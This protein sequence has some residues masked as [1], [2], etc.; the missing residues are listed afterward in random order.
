[1]ASPACARLEE[2]ALKHPKNGRAAAYAA[3]NILQSPTAQQDPAKAELLLKQ[4][5]PRTPA[6]PR[7]IMSLGFSPSSDPQW[8]Q[9]SVLFEKAVALR[10]AYSEAHYRLSRAYAHMGRHDEAQQQIALQQQYSQQEKDR[11]NTR[12]QEMVTFLI[13]AN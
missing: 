12:M 1:M 4:A 11:L 8:P 10:P 2:F 9:S 5:S 3:T 7:H 13:Q 6:S